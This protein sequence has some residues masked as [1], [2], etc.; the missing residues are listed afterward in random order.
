MQLLYIFI[1]LILASKYLISPHEFIFK[2][3][4]EVEYSSEF[5]FVKGDYIF[6]HS[7]HQNTNDKVS[8]LIVNFIANIDLG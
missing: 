1:N 8:K 3:L 5:S 6:Y 4:F 7:G 2:E